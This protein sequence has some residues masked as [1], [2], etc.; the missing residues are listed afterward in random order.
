[1]RNLSFLLV[2]LLA[3]CVGVNPSNI[4]MR[5][6]NIV[7][8]REEDQPEYD[9]IVTDPGYDTWLATNARPIWYYSQNYLENKN[10][11]YV[12]DWNEKVTS[13]RHR[14]NTLFAEPINYDFTIDYG[15]ELNYKLFN[16]FKFIHSK[17]GRRY[18][19]PL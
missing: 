10:R 4:Y 9:L 17:Y 3:G 11:I 2:V 15:L 8:P 14:R 13:F 6:S 19:F 16:Y 18:A 5:D 12:S 1:M 7:G